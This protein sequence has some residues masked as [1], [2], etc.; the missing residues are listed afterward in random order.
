WT[1][2]CKLVCGIRLINQRS[3]TPN[4]IE[5]AD[6]ML[7][8]WEMEFEHR[9]YGREFRRLHFIR[10]CVHVIAHG[11]RETVRCGPL[12][13]LAQWALENTIG[14]LKREIHLHSNPYINLAE[15]GVL[16]AQM[17]ALKILIPYLD[18]KRKAKQGSVDIGDGYILLR[19]RDRYSRE[20]SE[21]EANAIQDFLFRSGDLSE[22]TGTQKVQKWARLQL[23]NG[24]A[25]RSVWKED[26]MKRVRFSRNIKEHV[27]GIKT[28]LALVSVYGE[29]DQE[30][31]EQS[32]GTLRV[33]EYYGNNA[34]QVIDA[35]CIQSVV[36]MVPFPVTQAELD[37][38]IYDNHFFVGKKF[39]IKFTLSRNEGDNIAERINTEES[40]EQ[41]SDSDDE[42]ENDYDDDLY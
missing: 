25:A 3:I 7:I 41:E 1:H 5:L 9:Y 37:Q 26:R 8:E 31:L 24:Q 12:N 10:P 29:P 27:F 30:L 32:H 16:R 19:A 11:A 20:V 36:A 40:D 42:E 23:P 18:R 38:H 4:E 35:K 33:L 13:L 2:Y 15:C 21:A 28:A 17:N 34:L 6:R 22:A 14:N 39:S